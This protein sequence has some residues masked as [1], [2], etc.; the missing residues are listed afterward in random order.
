MNTEAGVLTEIDIESGTWK[1]IKAHLEK[2]LQ[3]TREKNDGDKNEEATAKL[4]GRIAELKYLAALDSPAPQAAGEHS[5][6]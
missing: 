5:E 1:K 3:E 4:R 2:R 6:A